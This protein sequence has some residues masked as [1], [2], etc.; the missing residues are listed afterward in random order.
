MLT[1]IGCGN[2]NRQDD[3][4]GVHVA[5]RIRERLARHPVPGVQ[6]LD[7]GT[8][9]MEVMFAAKGSDAVILVDASA[10]GSE[11][12]AVFEVPGEELERE[13]EPSL[14]LHDL[15]WDDALAMG[16]KVYGHDFPSKV[17]VFLV[18][19]ARTGLGLELSPEVEQ[20]AEVV[21][22]R[23]L[24]RI[25]AHAVERHAPEDRWDLTIDR[26]WIQVPS[27]VYDRL[28][29]GREGVVP[30]VLEQE[31]CIMPV[32]QVAGGL[33]VKLRNPRG[34][35]AI[36]AGEFLRA[37]GWDDWGSYPVVAR[38][39]STLGALALAREESPS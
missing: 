36:D 11:P 3:A 19:A 35:R 7:C 1:I 14:N 34:D 13:R 5:R 4:V 38:W 33:L 25:A 30:F 28:F 23:L 24:E 16:R 20:A 31:V 9:G 21:Y 26:G 37:N 15:R 6:A 32:E 39:E 29:E 10:S 22:Q 2:A 12:G 18:E 27:A 17:S 8:G